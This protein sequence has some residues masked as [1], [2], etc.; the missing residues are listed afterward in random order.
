M[1]KHVRVAPEMAPDEVAV[2]PVQAR[3]LAQMTGL[4][5]EDFAG[6]TIAHLRDRLKWIVDPELW[7]FEEICGQVVKVD[8][9]T[10]HKYPVPGATVNVIDTDCDWLWYFPIRWPWSWA[11]PFGRCETE[12]LATTTT[13]GC[14]NFCVWVPRFDIDWVLEW[15]KERICLPEIL[16]RPSIADLLASLAHL[17]EVSPI[18]VNPN[19]P[20]PAELVGLLAERSDLASI[21]GPGVAARLAALS[22]VKRLGAST[23]EMSRLLN[24]R[25]FTQPVP[26]PIHHELR[27]QHAAGDHAAVAARLSI[28][29]SD[30]ER[31]RLGEWVGP[32]LRCF[33]IEVPEWV[34]F[35]EVP[36]IT[37]QVTQDVDGDGDQEVIYQG[38]FDGPWGYSTSVEL[39][40]AQFALAIPTP[41][42][43]PDFPCSDTPAIEMIGVMPV[44]PGF[45]DP[46]TGFATRPNRS[47]ASGDVN[48][49]PATYPSTAPF[50]GTLPLYGCVDQ[51]DNADHYRIMAEYAPGDGLGGPLTYG[52][53]QPLVEQWH[54][55]HFA[56]FQDLL[57]Q[58][59]DAD[60]WYTI[61]DDSW[62]P[63]HLL[64]NWNPAAMGTYRLTLELGQL[65][66]GNI[67]KVADAPQV[68]V[69]VDN[70]V[71][72]VSIA[73]TQWGTTPTPDF[74]WQPPTLSGTCLLIYRPPAT[75]IWV[76][77]VVNVTTPHLRGVGIS[78][79]GCGVTVVPP[80]I[81]YWH[82]NE[83]DN[84]YSN[85]TYYK[86]PAGSQQGCYGWSVD[87]SSRA[88]NPDGNF[89]ALG[90]DFFYDPEYVH[91]T[92][93][94]SV[95]IIDS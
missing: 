61:L 47:R 55:F 28:E 53:P 71:P 19:P 90:V 3:R 31:L 26:P 4:P 44:D 76:E 51:I 58:P 20:D 22:S 35:L 23:G 77:V 78:A 46:T 74:T 11:F 68:V 9:A 6:K 38:A 59:V 8:P 49:G 41:G 15:R 37:F 82:E 32:Y 27:Q 67:V 60:G 10:G 43:G 92:P 94:L 62:W 45:L 40:A 79:S 36:D 65:Q 57:R 69:Y 75:D 14:G 30:A 63:V 33:D 5:A 93:S 16:R 50:E 70:T 52:S 29:S 24:G 64:M 42:C 86:I 89:D 83:H 18:P 85:T 73:L 48:V 88:F 13:D 25:A 1:I 87:A 84:S 34:P 17:A 56:P 91:T 54:M 2:N 7:L 39:D 95:A 66:A 80:A 21:V 12:T 81:G 72:T